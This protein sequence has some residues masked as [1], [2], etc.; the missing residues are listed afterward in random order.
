MSKKHMGSGIDEFLKQEGIFEDA[1]TQAIKEIAAWQVAQD[2]AKKMMSKL[3]TAHENQT[4]SLQ[5]LPQKRRRSC[6]SV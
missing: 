5:L 6:A 3:C 2:V 1:Q 4:S